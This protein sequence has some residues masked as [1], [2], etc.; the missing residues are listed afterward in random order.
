MSV[1][2][3]LKSLTKVQ[4][5]FQ[6]NGP[7]DGWY[8]HIYIPI[9]CICYDCVSNN[10]CMYY[11]IFQTSDPIYSTA[12][13]RITRLLSCRSFTRSSWELH[14]VICLLLMLNGNCGKQPRHWNILIKLIF[15]L[16]LQKITMPR[17]L[18][19][20]IWALC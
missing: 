13:T 14:H 9:K 18:I 16:L 20:K 4:N 17:L 7:K 12:S 1:H 11:W 19:N 6:R 10:S 15:W 3:K 2:S 8:M 5:K